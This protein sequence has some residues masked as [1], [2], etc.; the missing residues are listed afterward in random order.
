MISEAIY[1]YTN[2]RAPATALKKTISDMVSIH[3]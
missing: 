1:V 3:T 2:T